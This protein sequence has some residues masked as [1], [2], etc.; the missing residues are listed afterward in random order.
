MAGDFVYS[1]PALGK[2]YRH[3][4]G[5]STQIGPDLG[6]TETVAGSDNGKR[7]LQSRVCY[8]AGDLYCLQAGAVYKYTIGSP[9]PG[10]R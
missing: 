8:W 7:R 6:A 10:L 2:V 5:T 9:N 3:V 1:D 4:S